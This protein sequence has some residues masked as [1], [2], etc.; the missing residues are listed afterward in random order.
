MS[1]ILI[2]FVWLHHSALFWLW[3][4]SF[5]S[6][7]WLWKYI[8]HIFP[9]LIS[10]HVEPYLSHGY[11][12]LPC[13]SFSRS[14]VRL[15]L[16]CDNTFTSNEFYRLNVLLSLTESSWAWVTCFDFRWAGSQ[17]GNCFYGMS[18]SFLL[19][20]TDSKIC[21]NMPIHK[22]RCTRLLFVYIKWH[23]L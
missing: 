3:G 18:G 9:C 16:H 17:S 2:Y 8:V 22:L 1:F 23:H 13:R 20:F 4:V 7:W 6:C 21:K 5:T 10:L 19:T 12:L 11:F 15:R 14:S